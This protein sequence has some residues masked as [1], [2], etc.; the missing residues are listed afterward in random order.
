MTTIKKILVPVDFSPG[1]S[2]ALG[3]AVDLSVRYGASLTIL[4]VNELISN[5]IPTSAMPS[6]ILETWI[7]EAHRLLDDNRDRALNAGA[8]QVEKAFLQGTPHQEIVRFASECHFDLIVMG[9]HGRT[10]LKH[11]FIGS[12]AERVV[13]GASCPVLTVRLRDSSDE[14][15]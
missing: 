2:E 9:T 10:G 8:R 3:F 14:R 4:N 7:G 1:A 6:S 15:G 13:R 5:L 12:V 11:A